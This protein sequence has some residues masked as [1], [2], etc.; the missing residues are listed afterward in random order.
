MH[1]TPAQAVIR[2][3]AVIWAR[4]IQPPKGRGVRGRNGLE[5]KDVI[6]AIASAKAS[7]PVGSPEPTLTQLQNFSICWSACGI[8]VDGE[9]YTAQESTF[10]DERLIETTTAELPG[11]K[12]K[13]DDT[14]ADHSK[15]PRVELFEGASKNDSSA[16][17]SNEDHIFK[18]QHST[19]QPENSATGKKAK[20]R[21]TALAA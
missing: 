4:N 19:S 18:E 9:A 6:A 8:L 16:Q 13:N 15:K 7:V 12:R 5:R 20:L 11:T 3:N 1:Q 21:A 10:D 17:P 14:S 2:L